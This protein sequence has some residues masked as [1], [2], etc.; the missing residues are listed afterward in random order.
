MTEHVTMNQDLVELSV[1]LAILRLEP[2]SRERDLAEA[3]L[4]GTGTTM[5]GPTNVFAARMAAFYLEDQKDVM[6]L[7][8]N[9]NFSVIRDAVLDIYRGCQEKMLVEYPTMEAEIRPILE[10][11]I[12]RKAG[13]ANGS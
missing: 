13:Q 11:V 1:G 7:A 12:A 4:I 8:S 5:Y 6:D 3:V 10:N 9:P 2:A